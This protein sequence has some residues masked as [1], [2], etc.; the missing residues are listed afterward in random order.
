MTTAHFLKK[1]HYFYNKCY[2]RHNPDN[3]GL[4]TAYNKAIALVKRI[5]V[6]YC[7]SLTKTQKCQLLI[8]IR[9]II[10]P[11]DPT[12]AVYV[13]IVEAKDNKFRQYIVI[14]MLDLKEQSQQQG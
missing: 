4:A 7:C 6:K 8:L 14:N 2:Y 13:P 11:L 12:V 10:M 1:M 5:N 3:P 9:C